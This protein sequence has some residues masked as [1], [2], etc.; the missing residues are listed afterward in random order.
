MALPTCQ[1][2]FV[3]IARSMVATPSSSM[4]ISQRSALDPVHWLNHWPT[5][6]PLALTAA[7]AGCG[8]PR[9]VAAKMTA[10]PKANSSRNAEGRQVRVGWLTDLT[11]PFLSHEW[12]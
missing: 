4:V 12:Y 3:L 11:T 1:H 2:E 5:K 7:W 9:P 10:S 6:R 8:A